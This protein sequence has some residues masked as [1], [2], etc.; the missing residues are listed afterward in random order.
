MK[1]TQSIVKRRKPEIYVK[2]NAK[3]AVV[4][5]SGNQQGMVQSKFRPTEDIKF[6]M[7]HLRIK[8]QPTRTEHYLQ[9]LFGFLLIL[10]VVGSN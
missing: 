4:W 5:L 7:K 10:T 3:T 6:K 8:D 2:R 9:K 1:Q